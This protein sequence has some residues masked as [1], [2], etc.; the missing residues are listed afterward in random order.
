MELQEQDIALLEAYLA[1]ELG[2]DALQAFEDRLAAEPP[3]AEALQM[4]RNMASATALT[5]KASLKNDFKAAQAA[6]VAAGMANYT[7]SINAPKQ[8][9]SFLGKLL[10]FLLK[11][12]ITVGIG[13]VVWKYVLHEQWPPQIGQTTGK[14]ESKSSTKSTKTIRRD[15]IHYQ[16]QVPEGVEY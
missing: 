16:K 6:A 1:G 14:G 15:T 2:G 8:G 10:R 3:L 4:L 11:L 13:W 9:R 12:G 7:P 5:A